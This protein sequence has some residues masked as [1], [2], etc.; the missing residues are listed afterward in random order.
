MHLKTG[1]SW[2]R[3][4][5]ATVAWLVAAILAL[6]TLALPLSG[7]AAPAFQGLSVGSLALLAAAGVG[8]GW[9]VTD[10]LVALGRPRWFV[11]GVIMLLFLLGWLVGNE[12]TLHHLVV[13]RVTLFDIV[14]F[15]A[16]G[17]SLVRGDRP[18][19]RDPS[20]L[21]ALASVATWIAYDV[22][23]VLHE[24]MRDLNTYLAA[25]AD[26]VAGHSAYLQAPLTSLPDP[27]RNPFVY[28]PLTLP[29]FE[30]LSRLPA[31][32]VDIGWLGLSVAAVLIGLSVLGIRGRWLVALLA[33][34]NFAIAFSVGNVA[35][36]GF[37]CFALGY[38]FAAALVLG[39][40][41]KLQSGVVAL[42]GL[43]EGRYREIAFGI[44]VL[45]G[46]A[47]ASIAITGTAVWG[48][49]ARGLGYFQQTLDSFPAMRGLSL[50]KY[51][52]SFVVILAGAGAI[53]VALLRRG[54]NGLARFGLASIIA[55]PTLY[56]H[57]FGPI[58][59]GALTLRPAM[60]WFVL[61][62]FPWGVWGLPIPAA[63]VAVAIVAGALLRS[64]G[65]DLR[66]PGAMSEEAAD[67]HPVG[68]S[69]Q[70]WPAG[71]P[72]FDDRAESDPQG[73]S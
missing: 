58:L 11:L 17:G 21:V 31:R 18:R 64:T 70:I 9:F 59:P 23:T 55:S 22:P 48:E 4:P 36:F 65:E 15:G 24:P 13:F 20:V 3:L 62:L 37:L 7:Y 40:I 49:W 33:W 27:D 8:V 26:A 5:E 42:W 34:P 53:L 61:A 19:S 32:A 35:V 39:G 16:A 56:I 73:G 45:S 44:A 28:P 67:L 30:L 41:F 66:K 1:D 51:L 12:A 54:R 29:L 10:R 71:G 2:R 38:R 43:R 72:A 46:I 50:T 69:L 25:A 57:G 47:L 52:P 60:F 68:R 63:W 6:A 14:L